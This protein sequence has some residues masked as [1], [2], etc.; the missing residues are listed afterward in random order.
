LTDG[1]LVRNS[2]TW[3]M[4]GASGNPCPEDVMICAVV[5]L[6]RL[7]AETTELCKSRGINEHTDV[8][9]DIVLASCNGK[10][11]DWMEKWHNALKRAAGQMFHFSLLCLY[12]LHTRLYLNGFGLPAALASSRDSGFPTVQTV[13]MCYS[14]AQQS[15]MIVTK[16]MA[17]STVLRYAPDSLTIMMA[18]SAVFLLKL[19]AATAGYAEFAQD[20]PDRTNDLITQTADSYQEAAMLADSMSTAAHHSRFLRYLVSSDLAQHVQSEKSL[21]VSPGHSPP[22]PGPYRSRQSSVSISHVSEVNGLGS[23][24]AIASSSSHTLSPS[25]PSPSSSH[26]AA[27]GSRYRQPPGFDFPAS[28]VIIDHPL[29]AG[30]NKDSGDDRQLSKTDAIYWKNIFLQ[31]GFGGAA[32]IIPET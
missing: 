28:P 18:Y 13:S 8:N 14:S 11:T 29:I 30:R 22:V 31:L 10:L 6:R 1:D 26:T 32:E 19:T 5:E 20:T 25:P 23:S 24:N 4:D 16:E 9:Y 27:V 21:D 2:S 3:Y 17:P 7:T 15:L 12:R